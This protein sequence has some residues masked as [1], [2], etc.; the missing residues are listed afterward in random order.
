V[1]GEEGEAK[2]LDSTIDA[3]RGLGNGVTSVCEAPI[4]L[5]IF[6]HDKI[7]SVITPEDFALCIV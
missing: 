1:E 2:I 3:E 5:S 7:Q 6:H 4:G